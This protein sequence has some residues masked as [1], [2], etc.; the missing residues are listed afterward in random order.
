MT[1]PSEAPRQTPRQTTRWDTQDEAWSEAKERVKGI[2]AELLATLTTQPMT[3]DQLEMRHG[4]TH[5]T[6]SASVN[7]LMR[8]G[9]IVRDGYGRTRSNRRAI[10]W[11]VAQPGEAIRPPATRKRIAQDALAAALEAN[12]ALRAERDR[13]INERD[14]ARMSVCFLMAAGEDRIYRYQRGNFTW[15]AWLGHD[16]P[17]K[18]AQ[19]LR[20]DCFGQENNK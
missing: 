15:N 19:M 1:F 20:W 2:A 17:R 14:N 9:K 16:D 12:A 10:V 11:R 18:V 5:Q 4:L 13:A 6:C 7:W 3:C 8:H